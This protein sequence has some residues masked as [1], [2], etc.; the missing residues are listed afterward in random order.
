MPRPCAVETHARGYKETSGR[1]ADATALCRGGSRLVLKLRSSIPKAPSV[2]LHGASPWHLRELCIFLC[3]RERESPRPK[4]VASVC[5]F[6][7]V[8]PLVRFLTFHTLYFGFSYFTSFTNC[9]Y[10][11]SICSGAVESERIKS[12]YRNVTDC[13]G[14]RVKL[15]F[16]L[17]LLKTSWPSGFAENRP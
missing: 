17:P 10:C 7:Q 12:R 4:A 8:L 11:A 15:S 3:S 2:K 13:F 16:S 5:V 14:S 9:W 1:F 6:T